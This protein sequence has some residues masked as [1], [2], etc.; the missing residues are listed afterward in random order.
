MLGEFKYCGGCKT[1]KSQVPNENV[2]TDPARLLAVLAS[3]PTIS[4][5]PINILDGIT[6][7]CHA[8]SQGTLVV[9]EG[10]AQLN[11]GS[12]KRFAVTFWESRQPSGEW[13]P[14]DAEVDFE[15]LGSE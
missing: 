9:V 10:T 5:K 15:F 1:N 3:I 2:F 14:P 4:E 6:H 8:D 12:L 11:G 7:A 13:G